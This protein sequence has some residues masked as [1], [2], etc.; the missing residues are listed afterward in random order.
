MTESKVRIMIVEDEGIVGIDLKRTLIRLNYEVIAVVRTGE[1]AITTALEENPDLILMDIMLAGKMT[2]IEASEK[3]REKIN[4]PIIYLTAYTDS[5]TIKGAKTTEPFGY[6]VKPYDER[7]LFSTIEMALYKH[8]IN[9]RLKDSEERYRTLVELSPIAIGISCEGELV[10]VNNAAAK[11]FHAKNKQELIGKNI[12]DFIPPH[13]KNTFESRIKT[14]IEKN[15]ILEIVDEKI[16]TLNKEIIDIE[17]IGIPTQYDSKPAVQIVMRDITEENKR[18]KVQQTALKILQSADTAA[19]LNELYPLLHRTLSD[20]MTINNFYI[21]LYDEANDLLTFPYYVD[22]R[23]P[24]PEPRKFNNG[25]TELVI[26]KGETHLLSYKQIEEMAERG[27]IKTNISM[28]K[29]WLGVP[30]QIKEN[31][32]GVLVVKEYN[33]ENYLGEREKELLELVSFPISRAIERKLIEE[34]R[35]LYTKNLQKLNQTKDEFFSIIS[36]DLRSPFNS[37]LGYTDILKNEHT[38]MAKNDLTFIVESLYQSTRN[39]YTLLNNLLQF[40]RF[41]IGKMDFEPEELN[42]KEILEKNIKTIEGNALQKNIEITKE[43]ENDSNIYA[44]ENMINSVL[45]NLIDNAIKFTSRGGQISIKAYPN[46]KV[47]RIYV[48]DNGVGMSEETVSKLFNLNSK[49][50][51][52]GTENEIGTGLGLLL[53]KE[54]IEKNGGS[55]RV[56]SELGKG[57]KF[58][59]T[60][61]LSGN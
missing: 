24:A 50:S 10:F 32:I 6:I 1:K 31:N 5:E 56:E 18:E 55:L 8:T 27:E 17:F 25:L 45:Q 58:I 11:L 53:T 60:L 46:N 9:N 3:I 38:S 36:H 30:I 42:L 15:I 29:K 26:K 23:F 59:V 61:P 57:S 14:I 44:D 48:E 16:T 7:V 20:F 22:E 39:I 52:P 4:V 34:E 12:A 35:E 37:I 43:I 33:S 51:T 13:L 2:G 19:S 28:I 21:A 40:S 54:F 41:Q 47:I 49:N